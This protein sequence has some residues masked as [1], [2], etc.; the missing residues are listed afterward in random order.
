[1]ITEGGEW[2]IPKLGLLQELPALWEAE[3]R[4]CDDLLKGPGF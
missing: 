4:P 3:Q 2:Q 1:M